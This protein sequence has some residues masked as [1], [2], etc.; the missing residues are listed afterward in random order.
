MYGGNKNSVPS[1]KSLGTCEQEAHDAD[2]NQQC[3]DALA[4][5]VTE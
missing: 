3:I 1:F 2:E 5:S 4:E